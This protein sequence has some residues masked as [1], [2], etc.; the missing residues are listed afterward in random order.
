M[1]WRSFR[2]L[3]WRTPEDPALTVDIIDL[4][5]GHLGDAEAGGIGGHEDSAVLE[6]SDGREELVDLGGAQDD[7]ELALPFGPR[8]VFEPLVILKRDAVEELEGGEDLG[9]GGVSDVLVLDEVEQVGAD[10]S[11]G[12]ELGR[13]VEVL[14][15]LGDTADVELDGLWSEVAEGHVLDHAAAQRGHSSAPEPKEMG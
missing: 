1:T 15:E 7:R 3:P 11:L 4:Q 5:V 10:F 6:A 12:D 8:D 2:P 14:G 9:V 13:L